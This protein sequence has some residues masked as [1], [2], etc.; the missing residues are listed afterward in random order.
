MTQITMIA[1][2]ELSMQ[3]YGD[4]G[5]KKALTSRSK[6]NLLLLVTTTNNN[7]FLFFSV[8]VFRLLFFSGFSFVLF[9]FLSQA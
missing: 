8:S 2:F 4:D 7:S 6:S 1:I 3:L 9:S 5:N